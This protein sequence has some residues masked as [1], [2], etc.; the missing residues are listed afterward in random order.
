MQVESI[1]HLSGKGWS[2]PFP[3]LDSPQTLV[4]MFGSRELESS[5][6]LF[7]EIH[8]AFPQSVV[9]GCSTSGEIQG[10]CIHDGSVSP[11]A[12]RFEHTRLKR[13]ATVVQN[14][15]ESRAAGE[16]LATQLM[17]DDLQGVLILSD[18]LRVNGTQLVNGLTSVL[19]APTWVSTP[20][21]KSPPTSAGGATSTIRP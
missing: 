14:A 10:D 2:A 12:T 11:A 18:G 7:D 3:L 5:T 1:S 6:H 8:A 13:A 4:L 15:E 20:T 19:P 17:A 16:S 9:V 21:G